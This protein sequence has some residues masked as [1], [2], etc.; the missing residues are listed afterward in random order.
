MYKFNTPRRSAFR[1]SMP[2]LLAAALALCAIAPEALA[3]EPAA[4]EKDAKA[5]PAATT[6]KTPEAKALAAPAAKPASTDT[7]KAAE[8]KP[9]ASTTD[10]TASASEPTEAQ[11]ESAKLSFEAGTKAFAANDFA[12]AATEFQK[13]YAEV[14][15]PHAEYWIARA[16]DSADAAHEKTAEV[17]AAYNKF[18]SNPAA[19]HVGADKVAEGQ[20]RVVELK[21]LLPAQIKL[22]TVP[23]GA[24]VVVDGKA[25]EGATPFEM[26]LPAGAHKFE[27][28]LDGYQSTMVEMDLQGGSA[29]EQEVTLAK[30]APPAEPVATEPEVVEPAGKKSLVP[31][32]VTLGLGG[33]GLISG[34]LFGIMALGAKKDFND[35]PTTANADTAERN[36]LI[37]DMSFGI[38]LTLGITG[39][40][41]LTAEDEEAAAE[42]AKNQKFLVAPYADKKGGGLAGLFRF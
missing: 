39:V 27:L 9:E 30:V 8:P 28:S 19:Q 35:D 33:A 34:T 1:A 20:A 23:A 13:A 5:A 16:L 10:A 14:P 31:A 32:A 3:A 40:V 7:T 2:T 18:L 12:T 15:S 37:A 42:T 38:A 4:P 36:A 17:V 26:E 6:A 25:H 41:L 22:V 11:R 21:K 24:T 29:I